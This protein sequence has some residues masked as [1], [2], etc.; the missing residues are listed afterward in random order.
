MDEQ[1]PHPIAIDGPAASGKSTL[2]AALAERLGYA[3]LDTGLMYR[4]LTLAALE[5]GIAATDAD[6]CSALAE[7]VAMEIAA[8]TETRI[9]IDGTDVTPRLRE[10]AVEANVSAYSAI[11]GVREAMVA[12][13]RRFAA[14][15]RAVLAGRD[16]GTAVL[17][18]A[19]V[20]LYLE[21]SAEVRAQRRGEQAGGWGERQRAQEALNDISGRG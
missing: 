2:G 21:A 16:I 13:Q 8:N 20:K 7:S 14:D 11:P 3:F 15:R 6:A 17:P 4:A 1:L 18:N 12:R 19:P 9:L 10:P 5:G